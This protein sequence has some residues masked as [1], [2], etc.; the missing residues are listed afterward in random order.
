MTIRPVGYAIGPPFWARLALVLPDPLAQLQWSREGHD[1]EV[2]GDFVRNWSELFLVP[3]ADE[4]I[5]RRSVLP[6]RAPFAV[7]G[8][9]MYDARLGSDGIVELKR[10]E[11][12]AVPGP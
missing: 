6:A 12:V 9:V 3:G 2:G 5:W 4:L 8:W 11:Y 7:P 10:V 1:D